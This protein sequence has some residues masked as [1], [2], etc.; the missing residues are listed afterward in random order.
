MVAIDTH[1][2][3][4]SGR[5]IFI[6][7]SFAMMCREPV[8]TVAII[9]LRWAEANTTICLNDETIEPQRSSVVLS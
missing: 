1:I 9:K 3:E 2:A 6:T 7:D 8:P 5:N 4:M